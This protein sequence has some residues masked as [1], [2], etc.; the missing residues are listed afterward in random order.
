MDQNCGIATICWGLYAQNIDS[1]NRQ[2]RH[3]RLFVV[4]KTSQTAWQVHDCLS[5]HVH[6]IST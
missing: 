6:E 2:V 5:L 1:H 4:F 3:D